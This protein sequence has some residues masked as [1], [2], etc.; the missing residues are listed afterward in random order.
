MKIPEGYYMK[1]AITW[2]KND[3]LDSANLLKA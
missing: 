3:T 1:I 2:G